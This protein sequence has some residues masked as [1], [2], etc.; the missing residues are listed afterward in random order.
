MEPDFERFVKVL[1]GEEPDHVPFYEHL[2]DNEVIEAIIGEPIPAL[3]EPGVPRSGEASKAD[4]VKEGFVNCLLRFYKGLGYDYVPLE[5]P[6]NLPRTNIRL[7]KDPAPLSRGTRSGLTR[8]VGQSKSGKTLKVTRGQTVKTLSN[9]MCLT[10]CAR[11][12]LKA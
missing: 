7:G 9:T 12:C 4:S 6:L 10:G 8:T 3:L 2:V 1:W 11:F 5:L